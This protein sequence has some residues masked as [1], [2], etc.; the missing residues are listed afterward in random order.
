LDRTKEEL[1]SKGW[2]SIGFD[3]TLEYLAKENEHGE[4]LYIPVHDGKALGF[5]QSH[6]K[7][8]ITLLY[9]HITR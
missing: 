7:T 2:M 1:L 3:G 8:I 9:N 6:N 4:V 5:A